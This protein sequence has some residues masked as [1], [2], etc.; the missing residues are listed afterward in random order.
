MNH[1]RTYQ[2]A[3]RYG[4]GFLVLI[5]NVG[6]TA[7][8]TSSECEMVHLSSISRNKEDVSAS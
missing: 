3:I 1:C 5:N 4:M 8:V 7:K 6:L 2:G